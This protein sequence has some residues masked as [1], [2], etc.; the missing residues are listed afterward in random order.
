MKLT[1]PALT[2]YACGMLGLRQ[3]PMAAV[4]HNARCQYLLA[5]VR[6][7]HIFPPLHNHVSR[8]NYYKYPPL[9]NDHPPGQ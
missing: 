2:R 9:S 6:C 5:R 4:Y 7:G 3:S 8:K 1:S